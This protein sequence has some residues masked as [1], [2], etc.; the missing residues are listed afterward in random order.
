MAYER[1]PL[2][3]MTDQELDDFIKLIGRNGDPQEGDARYPLLQE[4]ETLLAARRAAGVT[5]DRTG[6]NYRV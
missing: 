5:V 1:K 3:E 2:K 6:I 4:A